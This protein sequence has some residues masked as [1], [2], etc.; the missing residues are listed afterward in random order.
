MKHIKRKKNRITSAVLAAALLTTSLIIGLSGT[1]AS[2]PDKQVRLVQPNNNSVLEHGTS[3]E[4]GSSGVNAV[5]LVDTS[6]G[7]VS[8]S[9]PAKNTSKTTLNLNGVKTAGV[10]AIMR[11]SAIGTVGLT[12]FQ[13]VD[14]NNITGYDLPNGGNGYIKDPRSNT[15]LS[16]SELGIKYYKLAAPATNPS[17]AE[18][19]SGTLTY[20]QDSSLAGKVTWESLNR[21]VVDEDLKPVGKGTTILYGTFTDRW[22]VKQTISYLFG[23]GTAPGDS[24]IGDNDGL[25]PGTDDDGDGSPDCWY[26][27]LK[28]PPNVWEVMD[29]DRNP[30]YPAEYIYSTTDDPDDTANNSP[31]Y[32]P[33]AG[34]FWVE[35]PDN[36]NI[37]ITVDVDGNLQDEPAIWSGAD[38]EW[39]GSDDMPAV[40]GGDG[41]YYVSWGQ[42]IFQK[43]NKTGPNAGQTDGN[44]LIGGGPDKIPGTSD[45]L[46]SRI[47][48]NIY[49]DKYYAGPF[50][51]EDGVEYYIGDIRPRADG[52]TT[53]GT[54]SGN[55]IPADPIDDTD[56]IYY[57]TDEGIMVTV[58][59]GTG[60]GGDAAKLL[61]HQVYG[62]GSADGAVNFSFVELY[63]PNDSAVL[64]DPYSLQYFQN[65]SD[66]SG[67]WNTLPLSGTIPAYGSFLIIADG[68][69]LTGA[70][71][72]IPDWDQAWT[73]MTFSN[74]AA[75][76]ALVKSHTALPAAPEASDWNNVV[77]LVG[78]QNSAGDIVYYFDGTG[79][80]TG[81]SKQKSARRIEFS[82]T[83]NNNVDFETLDYRASGITNEKLNQVKP[84][85]SADGSWGEEPG[86]PD[87]PGI[88]DHVI[89]NQVYGSG[90]LDNS[91]SVSHSFI[92]LYNPTNSS[93]SLEGY[94]IQL[95]NGADSSNP[96]TSWEKYDFNASHAIPAHSSFL[97]RLA[98]AAPSARYVI[99][100]ADVDWT[101]GRILSNRAYSSAL[102]SNQN[103][104]S[105]EITPEEMNGVIDLMGA[106]NSES[107]DIPKNYESVPYQK[108]SKQ[109]AARRIQFQD[110]G[111]NYNDFESIDYRKSGIS[112]GKLAEVRPRWSGDGPWN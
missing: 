40:K 111:N 47:F 69:E 96:A 1:F 26:R 46:E 28:K 87:E 93:I 81:I 65:P 2:K 17:A 23:V 78:I 24:N 57:M 68:E 9:N 77:D 72:I 6:L 34:V 88:L 99:P 19:N 83:G 49:D 3:F 32:G 15:P 29:E 35:D 38:S 75:S 86:E 52:V 51:G 60:N 103:L 31:A 98:L 27:Q 79:F 13:V 100:D 39:G 95:Q 67:G 107:T 54:G 91:G 102:V 55:T 64:L 109:Q 14:P 45:D 10:A 63:N 59:P 30:K 80:V 112:D 108:I 92:E 94:S 84:R 89:I 58:G 74:R 82:D 36:P 62:G 4:F 11:G 48:L 43:I 42:N 71:Y 12:N 25:K 5:S 73:G 110:T 16:Q 50:S 70:R 106:L 61:I 90:P 7:T 104:L 20:I 76:F 97:I 53:G 56:Q 18:N 22:G 37:Y 85:T 105:M 41:A 66:Q 44:E 8:I 101:S 21:E 33:Q